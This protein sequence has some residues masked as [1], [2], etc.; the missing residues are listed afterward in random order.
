VCKQSFVVV[1]AVSVEVRDPKGGLRSKKK[2]IAKLEYRDDMAL[3]YREK[4][5]WTKNAFRALGESAADAEKDAELVI[6]SPDGRPDTVNGTAA[7]WWAMDDVPTEAIVGISVAILLLIVIMLV[8]FF[9]RYN[10]YYTRNTMSGNN[11]KLES[12]SLMT[13]YNLFA[14]S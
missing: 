1:T 9:F 3:K 10:V 8:G 13:L 4:L 2:K 7:G 12:K 14:K 6:I 11:A 5:A